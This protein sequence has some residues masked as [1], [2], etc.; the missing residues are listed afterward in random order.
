[1][2]P[3]QLHVDFTL[4]GSRGEEQAEFL[5]EHALAF[6][7]LDGRRNRD[8]QRFPAWRERTVRDSQ[9][10][11]TIRQVLASSIQETAV[12]RT[13]LKKMFTREDRKGVEMVL[14]HTNVSGA[15]DRDREA[16]FVVRAVGRAIED[17]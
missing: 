17:A 15:D 6:R 14:D 5:I 2:N 7:E 4:H 8:H 16:Q 9:D 1:M 13:A 10:A 3:V 11:A 12:T